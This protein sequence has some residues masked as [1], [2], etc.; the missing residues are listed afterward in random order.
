MKAAWYT[1]NGDAKDVLVVGD[2]PTP[3][4][5][6][7]EVRVHLKTSGVNPSDVKNRKGRPLVGERYI[8]HSDGAGVIDQ[9]GA[10]VDASRMGQR[11][12][13]WNAQ[14]KRPF[15]TAAQYIVLPQAQAHPL[16]DG[17]DFAAGACMGIPGLTAIQAVHLAGD[18]KGKT[19]LVTGAPSAV[20]HYVSQMV[21][22][23]GGRVIGTAGSQAKA[24]HAISVGVK[25]WINYKTESVPERVKSL[26]AGKGVDAIIDMDFSTTATWLP[27]GVL[28]PEGQLI[29]Y[30]SNA[31]E[32]PLSFRSLLINAYQLKFFIVYE[33]NA[34]DR[35]RSLADLN[36]LL[37][38]N[39]LVHGIGPRFS[40]DQ[41]VAAH[42]CVEAGRDI[43]NV[44]IDI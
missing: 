9:V 26:T 38:Q 40:L 37:A 6:P 1:H 43:G 11:V 21:M 30:G 36:H 23:A 15:G 22:L 29:C 44:V 18:L 20:G 10:G 39:K 28:A 2:M 19:V 14:Y 3:Q 16:P 24:D 32:T 27:Q 35:A 5:G 12:W 33:L 4:A 8:P 34:T 13:T 41:V 7:G 31:A 25:D 17:T 42:E